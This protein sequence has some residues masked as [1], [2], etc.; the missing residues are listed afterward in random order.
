MRKGQAR[1]KADY[2]RHVRETPSFQFDDY[3]FVDK[4]PLATTPENTADA[5]AK[6]KYNKLQRPTSGPY[7]IL[8]VRAKTAIIDEHGIPN[9]VSIHRITLA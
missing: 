3:V 1:Y 7:R 5:L 2:D 6:Q 4:P 9:T 8:E